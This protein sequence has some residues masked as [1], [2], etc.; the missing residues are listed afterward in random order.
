MV[1]RLFAGE[2]WIRT[3]GSAGGGRHPRNKPRSFA[4]FLASFNQ[5]LKEAG[6]VDQQNVAIEYRWAEGRQ[7]RL[8]ELA[9]DLVARKVD[10]I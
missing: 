5:G 6:Y 7:D 3:I 4:P 9:G 8:P 2:S 1:R 10:V